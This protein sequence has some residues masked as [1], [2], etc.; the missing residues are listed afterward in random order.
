MTELKIRLDVSVLSFETFTLF[1][2]GE[3]RKKNVRFTRSQSR[4]AWP[5]NEPK[6]YFRR[7]HLIP[8]LLLKKQDEKKKPTKNERKNKL[9]I[10][11]TIS[12]RDY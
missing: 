12:T 7:K 5:S 4:G 1:F 9:R 11:I 3:A 10:T 8:A 2:G 6:A